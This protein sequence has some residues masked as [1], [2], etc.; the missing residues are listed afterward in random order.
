MRPLELKLSAFGPYAGQ[1]TIDFS[2]F[3]DHG[4]YLIYGDTGSGKTMLFDAIAYALFGESSG[5]RDVRTLRSDFADADKPTEVQLTFEHA[6]ATY[7]VRRRP[8][9]MLARR[10]GGGSDASSLVGNAPVAELSCGDATLATNTRAVNEY[11]IDLLGLSYGQFR[12]VTMIAQ[13]AFRDLLCTDPAERE[14]VL[15]KIFGTE[16]LDRF[17][18][19]LTRMAKESY[20]ALERARDDFE[21]CIGRLDRGI[22]EVH[23]PIQR[24]LSKENPALA[25]TDCIKAVENLIERQREEI[26]T[27]EITRDR[28]REATAEARERL[29]R[30]QEM[31][32]AL[33][34]TTKARSELT[35]ATSH[36][37]I[38]KKAFDEAT[39]R[40]AAEYGPLME[41]ESAL[42]AALPRYDELAQ[43][44]AAAL[45][46]QAKRDEFRAQREDFERRRG[47]LETSVA[48]ARVE[49]SIS[50]DVAGSLERA[51]A[52]QAES[53]RKATQAAEVAERLTKLAGERNRLVTSAAQVEQDRAQAQA[54]RSHADELFSLLV[55]D[56]AAFVASQLVAG[57]PCPVCGS[58][59]H[60]HPAHPADLAPDRSSLTEAR[61]RQEA[62]EARLRESEDAYLTLRA[63]V[64]EQARTCLAEAHEL[65][66]SAPAAGKHLAGAAAMAAASGDSLIPQ[67]E[68]E[69]VA[70]IASLRQHLRDELVAHEAQ[71]QALTEK[72]A[73]L[74]ALREKLEADEQELAQIRDGLADLVGAFELASTQAASAQARVDEISSSLEFGSREDAQAAVDKLAKERITLE[75]EL[76][77]ARAAHEEAVT[78]LASA[79]SV[80]SERLARL[81]ELGVEEGD[82]TPLTAKAKRDLMV[83]QSAEQS[84]D[85]TVRKAELR[86]SRNEQTVREM[87]EISDR[88]PQLTREAAASDRVSRIARGQATG[89]NRISFERYVLG[90]YFDQI[91]ICANK[92]LSVMSAGHY[93]LVR[94]AE[95]ESRGKGGLSLDVVDYATGKRRPVSSL[96][97]GESFEASLALALGLSDYAQQRAGGMHLDTVFIDEGFG[98]LDPESLELVMRVLSDLASGDCLVGIISHVEELEQRIDQRIEVSSSPQGSH[99]QVVTD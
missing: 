40:H 83:A 25:S 95:G 50:Q 6:G 26:S 69:A 51:K 4:L 79:K 57:E 94:N 98:S 34:A 3:G 9:Q 73:E 7:T 70:Q 76:S 60:P 75:Q 33:D 44:K 35:R 53:Q 67:A 89:T 97:G 19:E 74:D 13:G 64:D 45:E 55:A 30:A 47:A 28:A 38:F 80:L 22:V 10:R 88:L 8:Q 72:L 96:S 31:V 1:E 71:T 68:Q 18:A 46:A 93:Q 20:E 82:D 91:V 11:L 41:R 49:L 63:Q 81:K 65:L 92:R 62:S 39:A 58:R 42:K 56:D 43:R 2:H 85:K 48:H 66:G 32:A 84:A 14:V 78:K 21:A 59:E 12:Q 24:V 86:V 16:E 15:R 17:A 77:L 87:R 27:A 37:S 99:V 61:A 29:H 90:F 36:V 23:D 5:S 52:E 54:D